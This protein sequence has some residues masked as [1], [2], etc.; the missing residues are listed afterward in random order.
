M[1]DR[2]AAGPPGVRLAAAVRARA[3]AAEA[4]FRAR[5]GLPEGVPIAAACTPF[6]T[7][8]PQDVAMEEPPP[9]PQPAARRVGPCLCSPLASAVGLAPGA[10]LLAFAR[11]ADAS[12]PALLLR[13]LRLAAV[14]C[15]AAWAVPT[16]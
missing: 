16:S 12:V 13:A 10:L 9:P 6:R 1:A 2:S 3:E 4:T 14:R 15:V 7:C 5:T 8:C 11:C